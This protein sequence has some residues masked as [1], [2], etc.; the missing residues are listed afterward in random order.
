VTLSLGIDIKVPQ[1][2]LAESSERLVLYKRLAQAR[3][4][5]EVDRLQAETEDRFGHPPKPVVNL[6]SMAQ[7]RLI[8]EEAGVRSVDLAE[9][10]LQ[11]RFHERPFV[12]PARLVEL[13]GREGG[14][15]TP[16]GMLILP[17]PPRDVDRVEAVR[18]VL[19]E[20]LGACPDEVH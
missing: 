14:S 5:D 20:M 6:F 4:A 7:L 2:Y 9:N 10:S 16:S 12:E 3:V 13:V 1:H 11:I 18:G 8:A 19:R 17:A 15:L